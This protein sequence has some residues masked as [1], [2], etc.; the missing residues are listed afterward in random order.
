MNEYIIKWQRMRSN[1]PVNRNHF[2][3]II[4]FLFLCVVILNGWMF[5]KRNTHHWSLVSRILN[6]TTYGERKSNKDS[7]HHRSTRHIHSTD[8]GWWSARSWSVSTY[9]E[10]SRK[11]KKKLTGQPSK[12]NQKQTSQPKSAMEIIFSFAVVT[13][14][15]IIKLL[16]LF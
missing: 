13:T 14:N 3:W 6:V 2:Y 15:N 8:R 12:H 9:E 10:S 1:S 4:F 7:K 5:W 11:M 16:T